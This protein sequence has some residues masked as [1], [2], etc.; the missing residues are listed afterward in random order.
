MTIVEISIISIFF[1][2]AFSLYVLI[3]NGKKDLTTFILVPLILIVGTI[4]GYSLQ[5]LKGTPI[6]QIPVGEVQIVS[7]HIEKPTIWVLVKG[8]GDSTPKFYGMP[9]TK[10]TAENLQSIQAQNQSSGKFVVVSTNKDNT[11]STE[12]SIKF[13]VTKNSDLPLKKNNNSAQ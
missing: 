11:E 5:L 12:K 4:S 9:Y 7:M 6:Y 1:L 3:Y 8:E 13:I 10:E 2:A